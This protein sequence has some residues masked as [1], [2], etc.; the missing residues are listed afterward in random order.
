MSLTVKP[1][2]TSDGSVRMEIKASKNSIGSFRS[3]G[4]EPSIDK[5][6]ATTNLLVKNGETTVI[7]G[8]IV[9]DVIQ[10]TQGVPFLKDVPGLGWLFK[11][12]SFSDTQK[13]L[14]IFITPTILDSVGEGGEDAGF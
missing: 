14:L 8:I 12:K 10:N 1:Q 9:S 5:K 13:E 2:I 4:G 7:G 3:A 11:N 6:E